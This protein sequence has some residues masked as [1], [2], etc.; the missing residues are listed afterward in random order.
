MS[1]ETQLVVVPPKET[2][3]AVFSTANGLEPWLQRVR[4]KVD[5]FQNSIPDLKT[6]KGRDAVA[7]MAHQ[8]AKSKTALEAVGK[9]ISAQQKEIP[10]KIDAERKRVWD[11]L[12][13]WQKEVR[14][15][16]TDWEEANDK[17]IDAHNDGIQR[18]KDLAVFAETPSAANVAQI[19]A[20][21][22]LV[23]INDSWEE[24]LAEAAQAKDRS[25]AT[26]RT[27]LADRTKHEAELAEI[28][29]FNAEKAEREQKE[30][31]AEIARQA[32]ERAHR[33]AEQ[34]AQAE[35]EAGARREQDLKD[36]AEA[37]QRAAEQKLR[38]AEA[39]AERQRL[40]IKLQEEQAERQ[41]LQA[42]QDRIAGMQ[43]AENERLAAEQRQAEAVER[44]RLAEVKRQEDAKAEELRQQKAR[45]DDKAHKASISRAALE[46][47]I[48]GGMPEDCARQAV[49]LIAQRKIP[50]I[51][52]A[53]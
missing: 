41:K 43:R 51:T 4:L 20:D 6:K 19:I 40:Q 15:P 26:L 44:A 46:A 2:A 24:F 33:E 14:K 21:L 36:Q 7:S 27:L 18:I 1:T 22:E 29:K 48:A 52:I 32:V 50:A 28:A 45:E 23:E 9:E 35:R 38:D 53:Y 13:S 47:F 11:M 42:E 3:L 5:E 31:D 37:Q 39:E 12:E 17:R 30:R 8:I 25:L 10:K 34:K 49:T 16:L